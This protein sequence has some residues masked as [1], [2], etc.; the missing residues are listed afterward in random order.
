[1]TF[2]KT[3]QY[4]STKRR[5]FIMWPISYTGIKIIQDQKIDEALEHYRLSEEQETQKRGLL[6]KSGA[7]LARFTHVS[8]QKPKALSP[9]GERKVE[10]TAS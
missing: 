5:E 7:F 2:D 8:A 3:R 10:E 1:M 6:Q 4:H 9:S